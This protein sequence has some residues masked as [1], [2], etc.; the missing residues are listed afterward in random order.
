[1]NKRLVTCVS[2]AIVAVVAITDRGRAEMA[3]P[4]GCSGTT[5]ICFGATQCPGDML[6]WCSAARGCNANNA[7]CVA[8]Q[9]CVIYGGIPLGTGTLIT[10]S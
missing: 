10:C 2:A 7:T 6:D 8:D 1:M 3:P 5:E 4:G 9:D